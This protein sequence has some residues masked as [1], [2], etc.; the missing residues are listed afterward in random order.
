MAL[1]NSD[2]FFK[3][4]DAHVYDMMVKF[5]VECKNK[6]TKKHLYEAIT[7]ISMSRSKM[8]SITKILTQ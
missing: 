8:E 5:V 1:S 4:E 2:M 6:E 3:L 7:L